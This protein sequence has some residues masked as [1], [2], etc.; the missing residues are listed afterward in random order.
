MARDTITRRLTPPNSHRHIF[1]LEGS[2]PGLKVFLST[3]MV[4][5]ITTGPVVVNE[6]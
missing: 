2:V 3:V 5:S 4:L 6:M 1:L